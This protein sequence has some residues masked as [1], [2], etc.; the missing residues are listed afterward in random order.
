MRFGECLEALPHLPPHYQL[1]TMS[2]HNAEVYTSL[3]I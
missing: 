2:F 3:C 1:E